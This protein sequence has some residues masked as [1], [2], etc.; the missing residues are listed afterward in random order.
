M[1]L[2]G[3]GKAIIFEEY[4]NKGVMPP[5][6]PELGSPIGVWLESLAASRYVAALPVF[7]STPNQARVTVLLAPSVGVTGGNAIQFLYTAGIGSMAVECSAN[8]AN[9]PVAGVGAAT[10]VAQVYLPGICR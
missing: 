10:T 8:A 1:V 2:A 6:Q 4:T 3:A 9:N 7:S 5:A